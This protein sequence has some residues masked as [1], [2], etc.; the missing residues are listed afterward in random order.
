MKSRELAQQNAEFQSF[1]RDMEEAAKAM[2]DAVEGL[3]K[4]TGRPRSSP[5]RKLSALAARGSHAPADPG[6]VW[7][8]RWRRWWRRRRP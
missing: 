2:N 6:R 7:T 3:K 8:A 4:R 1:A 5:N